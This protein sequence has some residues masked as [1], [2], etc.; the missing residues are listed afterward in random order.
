MAEIKMIVKAPIWRLRFF[1]WFLWVL[2]AVFKIPLPP[3][4]GPVLC[5]ALSWLVAWYGAFVV[6][7][8]RVVAPGKG[9]QSRRRSLIEA[10]ANVVVG[11][12]V[13]LGSNMI[14]L[15]L[16]GLPATWGQGLALGLAFT[17]ISLA[18]SFTLRRLFN[19]WDVRPAPPRLKVLIIGHGR[20]GKDAAGAILSAR[21]GLRSCSSSEFAAR[22]AIFP[23]VS[24]IYPNW[25]ACYADRGAHRALWFHAIAAYNLRPGPSLAAQVLVRHDIYTGMRKRAEFDLSRALFDCVLWI[26]R[27][28]HEAPEGGGSMELC[29][30]DADVVIDNNGALHDLEANLDRFMRARLRSDRRAASKTWQIIARILHGF[31]LSGARKPPKAPENP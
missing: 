28:A 18:R 25:R 23:I 10:C 11:F 17:L 22:H 3:A 1:G 27:S 16:V 20:H 15:P 29:A 8:V 24:D 26:D 30:A 12:C 2:A 7:G 14:L 4:L 19:S 9:G 13:A 31:D 21:H 6:R 5:R